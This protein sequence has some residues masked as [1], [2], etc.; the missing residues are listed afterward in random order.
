[1]NEISKKSPKPTIRV[2]LVGTGY[3]GRYQLKAW[4]RINSAELVAVVETS[5]IRRTELLES[6]PKER[7]FSKLEEMITVAQ[8]DLIDIATPPSTHVELIS[9]CMGKISTIVCQKPFCENLNAARSVVKLAKSSNNKLIVHEN[10]R[11]MPW[12]RSIKSEIDKGS[13]GDV[14]Q[15]TFKFRPGDGKGPDAYL[16]RQ[17]YFQ[18]MPRFLVHETAIHW[19]DVFRYLFGE[20]NTI[21]ADLWRSNPVIA[22]EDSGLLIMSFENGQRAVFDGSRTLDHPAK[23]H[24]LTLGE[25]IIEGSKATLRLDGDGGLFLRAFGS[26]EWTEVECPFHDLDFGGDCVYHFQ[27]HVISHLI[28]NTPIETSAE[29]YLRNLEVEEAAYLSDHESRQISL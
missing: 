19:I 8:P 15:A 24:R 13:L 27:K 7:I 25:M 10:F 9:K 2:A 29:D 1:M 23:N 12:Y 6:L 3:F 26:S 20:P 4:N 17:P 11:F 14:L 18:K 21:Y 16:S 5:P 28:E 22:G